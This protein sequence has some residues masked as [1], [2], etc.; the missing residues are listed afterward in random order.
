MAEYGP[1]VWA[2]Q[3]RER[4]AVAGDRP[5]EQAKLSGISHYPPHC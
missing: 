1:P 3:R 5:G 2:G 4:G